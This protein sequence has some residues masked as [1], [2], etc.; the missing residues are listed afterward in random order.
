MKKIITLEICQGLLGVY[1][2]KQKMALGNE[3]QKVISVSFI[4]KVKVQTERGTIH[5]EYRYGETN[6]NITEQSLK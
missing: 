2:V 5:G 4:N 1:K 6:T 3:E